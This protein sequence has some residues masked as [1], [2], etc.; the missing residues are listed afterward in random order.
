MLWLEVVTAQRN[1]HSY[2][3]GF[4]L[5]AAI[6]VSGKPPVTLENVQFMEAALGRCE[7]SLTEDPLVANRPSAPSSPKQLYLYCIISRLIKEQKAH[8]RPNI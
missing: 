7:F 5:R 3:P 4:Q 1:M 2:S 8:A 6:L